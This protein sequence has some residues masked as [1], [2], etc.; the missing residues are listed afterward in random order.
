MHS[1]APQK[2][3]NSDKNTTA[4]LGRASS[5]LT[6]YTFSSIALAVTWSSWPDVKI[7]W[8]SFVW[9]NLRDAVLSDDAAELP[10]GHADMSHVVRKLWVKI[11]RSFDVFVSVAATVNLSSSS[12]KRYDAEHSN[13]LESRGNYS[14]T[15]NMKLVHWPNWSVGCYIWYSEEGTM[16]GAAARPVPS[17]LYQM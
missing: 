11:R 13:P 17:S 6:E 15:W 1:I 10:D 5:P 4:A 12:I 2:R 8:C 3:C 16:G 7:A 9:Q 14:A